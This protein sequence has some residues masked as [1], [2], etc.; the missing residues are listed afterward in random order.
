VTLSSKYQLVLPRATRERLRLRPGMKLTVV[1]K[2]G[3][4]FLVPE[5]P[6]R[7]FRGVARGASAR[8]GARRRIASDPGRLERLDRVPCRSAPGC[9]L[10]PLPRGPATASRLIE[11]YEVYKVIRRD[12]SEE[13]ALEAVAALRRATI[14]PVDESLAL[15]AADL[16]LAHGLA[17]ADSLVYATARRHGATL[18][19]ADADF[20]GLPDAVV[21]RQRAGGAAPG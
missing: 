13:R 19:T 1:A 15:E 10:R 17:M 7:A 8:G 14:A 9:S 18:V 5:R 12:L 20:E 3:V 11:I 2:G 21:V 4:I 16:S 6:M